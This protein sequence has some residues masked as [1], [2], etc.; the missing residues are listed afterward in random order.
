VT[1]PRPARPGRARVSLRV[2]L[3]AAFLTA[4]A[5]VLC[6]LGAYVHHRLAREL[7]AGV[8][9]SL[10]GRSDDLV[11]GLAADRD[12]ALDPGHGLVDPDESFVQVLSP[13]GRLLDTTTGVAA[14]PLLDPAQAGAVRAPAYRTV[15]VPGLDDPAR[16][17][18]V[19]ALLGERPVLLVVG[20]TLGDRRDTLDRLL[21]VEAVAGP[22]ALLL[23]GLLGWWLAGAALRPVERLRARAARLSAIDPDGRLPLPGTA[24]ELDRL[25]ETLNDLLARQHEARRREHRFVDD[26]SH[27]LRTPLAVLRAELDLARSRPRTAEEYRD[28]LARLTTQSDRLVRLA[29]DLLVLAR[30]RRGRLP[31]RRVP[32]DPARLV[33]DSLADVAARL[34][35]AADDPDPLPEVRSTVSRFP[36]GG[37]T[38]EFDPDRLR[39]ALGNLIDNALRHGFPPVEVTAEVEE[40]TLALT[41]RDH[42]PGLAAPIPASFQPFAGEHSG[43]TG[44]GLAIVEAVAQAHDGRL[45][46]STH[47]DG[48]AVL[49]MTLP[50]PAV[51][52]LLQ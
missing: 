14:A 35:R 10:A 2:R 50:L 40:D 30:M 8:D 42:G 19:P 34:G 15:R 3:L 1:G 28:T 45:E 49:R 12:V 27:E 31:V 17:L 11:I 43:G 5:L 20:A 26:A 25:A 18:V 41:V 21:T 46:A 16:L 48:G 52:R 33:Q 23:T 13:A 32:T 36:A 44:L 9:R 38:V 47:P 29:D 22:A 4:M 51:R 37:G 6:G 24:D 39:Q 7:L